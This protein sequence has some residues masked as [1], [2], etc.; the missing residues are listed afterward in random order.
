VLSQ[1]H[2]NNLAGELHRRSGTKPDPQ[3]RA[4]NDQTAGGRQCPACDISASI[5]P[6]ASEYR[7]EGLIHHHWL[8]KACG[9]RWTT[10]V[11]LP[12]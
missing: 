1:A 6:A 7:G 10:A 3:P 9:H 8:C 12:A 11:H 5:A 4:N 2:P